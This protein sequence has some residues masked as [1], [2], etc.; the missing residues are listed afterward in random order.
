LENVLITGGSGFIGRRLV[1]AID[2]NIRILSRNQ[3]V[4]LETVICNLGFE[5]IPDNALKNIHTVIHLAGVAH[6]KFSEEKN[7]DF[8]FKVNVKATLEL[9]NLAVKSGVKKFIF[10][11]S[12]KAGGRSNNAACGNEEDQFKPEGIYGKTKREAEIELLKIS[13]KS[14]L[15]VSIIRPSLVCGP[16]VKGNLKLLLKGIR[17]GW[18]PPLPVTQNKRSIVH[19][20]DLVR[21]ILLIASD[22]R[23]NGEIYIVTDDEAYSSTEIYSILCRLVGKPI[24]KWSVPKVFFDIASLCSSNIKYKVEKLLGDEYY[25]SKKL[26]KLGF[27][28]QRKLDDMNETIF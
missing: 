24:P 20:D 14:E 22:D 23:S 2:G 27:K 6:N 25:S 7:E 3:S 15:N 10:I 16:G 28:T 13:K 4:N 19:V 9:A 8:F 5:P 26:K 1:N 12:V 11:S 18:F 21:A 17:S